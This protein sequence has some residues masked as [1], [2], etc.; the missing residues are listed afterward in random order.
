[1]RAGTLS[2]TGGTLSA[3]CTEFIYNPN[4]NGSTTNGAV[5]AIAQHN[6]LKAINVNVSGATLNGAK[7]IA[8]TDAQKNNLQNILI[9]FECPK[10]LTS[11]EAFA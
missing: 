5:I 1:M 10:I 6:T 8:V 2:V 9:N 4:D 11:L 7:T 3:S